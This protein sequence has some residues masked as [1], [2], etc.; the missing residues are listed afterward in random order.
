MKCLGGLGGV[1]GTCLEGLGGVGWGSLASGF[2]RRLRYHPLQD[3]HMS[4]AQPADFRK[5]AENVFTGLIVANGCRP[6]G[7]LVI[8]SILMG[9]F[10]FQ[11]KLYL[12]LQIN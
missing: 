1:S 7:A 4:S 6:L 9:N 10:H 2:G 5:S 12:K 8:L 11:Q 3:R